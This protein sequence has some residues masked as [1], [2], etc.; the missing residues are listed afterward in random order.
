MFNWYSKIEPLQQLDASP[1]DALVHKENK[2]A[3]FKTLSLHAE[4]ENNLAD[5]LTKLSNLDK[6]ITLP[7]ESNITAI[8]AK[9]NINEANVNKS[10]NDKE[11]LDLLVKPQLTDIVK[12]SNKKDDGQLIKQE[13]IKADRKIVIVEQ[14]DF[15][16][17]VSEQPTIDELVSLLMSTNHLFDSYLTGN[18]FSE[19]SATKS[20]EKLNKNNLIED[21]WK[22]ARSLFSSKNYIKAEQEYLELIKLEPEFADFYGELSNLYFV[23][24]E[25][26]KYNKTLTTLTRLYIKN[27]NI[28]MARYIIGLLQKES[29]ALAKMLEQELHHKQLE[30]IL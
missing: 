17:Y 1:S 20:K 27:D 19:I 8:V 13:N 18:Q 12:E 23:I 3:E 26:K 28:N 5:A 24:N 16:Q 10:V 6:K 15:V 21:K 4:K 30:I 9:E 29:N 25:I 7:V 2:T 11:K 22:L 14:N